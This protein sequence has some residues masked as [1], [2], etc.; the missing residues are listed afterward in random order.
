MT[1]K[2]PN[3]SLSINSFNFLPAASIWSL[4]GFILADIGFNIPL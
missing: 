3:A 4:I 1:E 2:S